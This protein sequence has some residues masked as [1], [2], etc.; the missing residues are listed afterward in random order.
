MSKI[1]FALNHTLTT[2]HILISQASIFFKLRQASLTLKD[3]FD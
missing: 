2:M 3:K 1:R